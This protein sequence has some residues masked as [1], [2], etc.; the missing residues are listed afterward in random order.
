MCIFSFL[1]PGEVSPQ[2]S[3]SVLGGLFQ[4]SSGLFVFPSFFFPQTLVLKDQCYASELTHKSKASGSVRKAQN[5]HTSRSKNSNTLSSENISQDEN[6]LQDQFN[7]SNPRV[8]LFFS[9]PA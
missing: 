1:P 4:S 5:K 3:P 6:I 8:C 9:K 7:F 2:F